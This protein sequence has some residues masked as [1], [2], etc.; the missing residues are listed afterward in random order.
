MLKLLL[1]VLVDS[2]YAVGVLQVLLED[3][4]DQTFVDLELLW[5]V[6]LLVLWAWSLDFLLLA[7]RVFGY[8]A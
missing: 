6:E 8:A 7:D 2:V 4:A 3:A 1:F 5:F